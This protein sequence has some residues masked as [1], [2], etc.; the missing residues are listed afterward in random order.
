MCRGILPLLGYRQSFHGRPLNPAKRP[1][2][3]LPYVLDT[4]NPRHP[5]APVCTPQS[6]NAIDP[7]PAENCPAR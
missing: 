6:S 3:H 2:S 7:S 5:S 1:V 4:A